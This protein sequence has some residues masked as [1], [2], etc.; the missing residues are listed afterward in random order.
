M[1]KSVS[2]FFKVEKKRNINPIKNFET[3]TA[4]KT[5]FI[6]MFHKINEENNNEK[7]YE[8]IRKKQINSIYTIEKPQKVYNYLSS[9][10]LRN[11][12]PKLGNIKRSNLFQKNK[13]ISLNC[14]YNCIPIILPNLGKIGQRK[15]QNEKLITKTFIKNADIKIN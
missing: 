2:L 15:E 12:F 3:L 6:N 9:K 7:N 13:H 5:I 14:I 4:N 11:N 10:K 1:K 8:E